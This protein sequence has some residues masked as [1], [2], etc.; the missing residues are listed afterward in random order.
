MLFLYYI[1]KSIFLIKLEHFKS[2]LMFF[3][4]LFFN[5][6]PEG[7]RSQNLPD[8]DKVAISP[9]P[10][11]LENFIFW[12][13]NCSRLKSIVKLLD[14]KIKKKTFIFRKLDLFFNSTLSYFDKEFN[15]LEML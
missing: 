15:T 5:S 7:I 10:M 2:A 13:I 4:L 14:N 1:L 9:P 11:R 6:L 3:K 8:E 12:Y